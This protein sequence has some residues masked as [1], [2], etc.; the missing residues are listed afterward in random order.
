M[1]HSHRGGVVVKGGDGNDVSH[2]EEGNG[3]FEDPR[4]DDQVVKG[5]IKRT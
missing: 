2:G 5:R 4:N 3:A 1:N